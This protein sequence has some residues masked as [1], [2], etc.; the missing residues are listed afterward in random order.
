MP[1]TTAR[2]TN[3]TL[4]IK[5]VAMDA[6]PRTAP[7]ARHVIDYYYRGPAQL[8]PTWRLNIK[9]WKFAKLRGGIT[10][11]FTLKWA[12]MQ[13]S[14]LDSYQ[15][16]NSTTILWTWVWEWCR[17]SLWKWLRKRMKKKKKRY[18]LVL[19]F[20][21]TKSSQQC[22]TATHCKTPMKSNI[23]SIGSYV[24]LFLLDLA[25]TDC[26]LKLYMLVKSARTVSREFYLEKRVYIGLTSYG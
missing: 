25:Q 10:S 26:L 3:A 19:N 2:I 8:F 4:P 5:R 9:Y 6:K 1:R 13:M 7:W 15:Y 20:P 23:V 17:P 12:E 22:K 18:L 24:W 21:L 14:T 11:Q 16:S